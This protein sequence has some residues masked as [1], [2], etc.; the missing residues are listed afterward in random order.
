MTTLF[1]MLWIERKSDNSRQFLWISEIKLIKLYRQM[2][3]GQKECLVHTA[4]WFVN[5]P[6]DEKN[7]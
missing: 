3:I 5:V 7:T 4:N 1:S 6:D 2:G